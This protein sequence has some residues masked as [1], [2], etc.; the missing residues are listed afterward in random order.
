MKLKAKLIWLILL[1]VVFSS[2]SI[3][4]IGIISIQKISKDSLDTTSEELFKRYDDSI[5]ANVEIIISELKAISRS[6]DEGVLTEEE[7]KTLA[8][9]IIREA[10]YGE[11]GYFWADDFE[12]NN[13]VLLGKDTEGT[14]RMGLQDAKG[15]MIIQDM[16]KIARNGGGFYDYYFPKP[17][18][19]EALRKRAY[20]TVFEDFQWEIGTGNYIDDIDQVLADMKANQNKTTAGIIMTVVLVTFLLIVVGVLIATVIG[21]YIAKP[22]SKMTKQIT[23]LG[24]LQLS[25]D[26]DLNDYSDRK[27]EVGEIGRSVYQLTG[28]M[29][30]VIQSI[31]VIS[32]IL[33]LDSTKL[34]NASNFTLKNAEAVMTAVDEFSSGIM[35][36]AN[37]SQKTAEA[38]HLMND[39][40]A[41]SSAGIKKV[42]EYTT[43]VGEAQT[44]GQE[45][46]IQLNRTFKDTSRTTELLSEDITNL[47]GHAEAIN[48]I[49]DIIDGIAGQTNLLALNASIEAARAGDAGKGFAVVASE[50]RNLAEQTSQSTA[51]INELINKVTDS[52]DSS[53][54][55]MDQSNHLISQAS[56]GIDTVKA[57]FEGIMTRTS[58]TLEKI[59]EVE[60]AYV[61]IDRSRAKTLEAIESISSVTE[62]SAAA[63]E[64]IN[65]SMSEQKGVT[66]ELDDIVQ[67]LDKE[68]VNLQQ[69]IDQFQL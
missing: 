22:I 14:N 52:I 3:A 33:N 36:Q 39:L 6:I 20:I 1:V 19:T 69:V 45:A 24:Q 35:E 48:E 66:S 55:N 58:K 37:D 29:R 63:A 15:S 65:A 32:D 34:V 27:D 31:R 16:M 54:K 17:N 41:S 51:K 64:E 61:E 4:G 42:V 18:E 2:L 46:V 47:M 21:N 28:K 62:E 57:A 5:R 13:I 7:G 40:L 53:K 23:K 38:I 8:A 26:Q 11:S 56:G 50:I 68:L 49:V 12:G 67:S 60:K 43:K 9:N 44:Q 30:E 10:R 59:S 25:A